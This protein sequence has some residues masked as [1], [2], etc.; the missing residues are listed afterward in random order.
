MFNLWLLLMFGSGMPALYLV[1]IAWLV[2]IELVDRHALG[3]LCRQPVRYGPRLPYLLLGASA[4]GR[5][6]LWPE[7]WECVQQMSRPVLRRGCN[8]RPGR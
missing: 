4:R 7:A 3:R 6:G 1:G 2:V 8:S 5:G